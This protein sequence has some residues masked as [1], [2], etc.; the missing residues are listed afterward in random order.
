MTL[1]PPPTEF[2]DSVR[3]RGL[4]YQLVGTMLEFSRTDEQQRRIFRRVL[5]D[6]VITLDPLNCQQC[7]TPV[8]NV[9]KDELTFLRCPECGW[10]PVKEDDL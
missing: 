4:W 5:N 1:A 7:G 2:Y 6:L 3:H 9:A 10:E 8:V